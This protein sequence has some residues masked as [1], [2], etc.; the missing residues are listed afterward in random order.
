MPFNNPSFGGDQIFGVAITIE[1]KPNPN[2]VQTDAFFGVTGVLSTAGGG[3]GRTF[4]V[5][6]VWV[7]P[8]V[9]TLNSDEAYFMTYSD[10]IART[11][12]DTR[13]RTWQN[14]CFDGVCDVKGPI[15]CPGGWLLTY[16]A[17]FRGLS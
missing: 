11:L 4:Q 10:S 3:R 6:G 7:E 14:V 1:Q 2:A 15:A 12:I 17:T 5:K 8:D 13:G 16:T 9:P